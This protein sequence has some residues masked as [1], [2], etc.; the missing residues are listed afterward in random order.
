[1]FQGVMSCNL[2]N[3]VE[4]KKLDNYSQD[5]AWAGLDWERIKIS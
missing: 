5:I 3:C 1:M 4:H 2:E